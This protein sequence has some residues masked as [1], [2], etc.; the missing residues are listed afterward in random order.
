MIGHTYRLERTINVFLE[1]NDRDMIKEYG[2]LE[3]RVIIIDGDE[4]RN[5]F[6]FR[7]AIDNGRNPKLMVADNY[8]L[9][10]PRIILMEDKLRENGFYIFNYAESFESKRLCLIDVVELRKKE[11]V[12]SH[13]LE[14][15]ELL[16]VLL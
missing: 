12:D 16:K 15:Y 8:E 13:Y 11:S 6:P 4:K 5:V 3:G 7:V 10:I 1:E 14:L 2:S 9:N